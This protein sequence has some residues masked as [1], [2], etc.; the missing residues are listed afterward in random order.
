LAWRLGATSSFGSWISTIA[1]VAITMHR[2][3]EFE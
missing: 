2:W 3:N 1:V